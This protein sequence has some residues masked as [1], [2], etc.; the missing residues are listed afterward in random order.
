MSEPRRFRRAVDVT[1]RRLGRVLL[2]YLAL[3]VAI[4]TLAPFNFHPEAPHGLSTEWTGLDLVLN[5]VMF[6]PL[7]FVHALMQ[8]RGHGARGP[9]APRGAP[10]WQR[11][12]MPLLAFAVG[13]SGTIE[14]L[15]TI[16]PDRYP[17]LLDLG[18]NALGALGGGWLFHQLVGQ[19]D[20]GPV[21]RALSLELPLM[22]VAY[23]LVPLAWLAGLGATNDP[24]RLWLMLPLAAAAGLTLGT[25]HGRFVRHATR[26]HRLWLVIGMGLWLVVSLLPVAAT[27]FEPAALIAA[28]AVHPVV[29]LTRSLSLGHTAPMRIERP[30]VVMLVPLLLFVV[31]GSA[32]W[33]LWSPTHGIVPWHWGPAMVITNTDFTRPGLVHQL[34]QVVA[35]TVVGYLLAE[36]EGRTLGRRR[37]DLIRLLA[38]ASLIAM[39][40]EAAHGIVPG[41]GSSV[42]RLMASIASASFGG[43]VYLLFRAQ[44]QA[45]TRRRD[46][47]AAVA[48]AA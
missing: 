38:V 23:L 1:A 13:V 43:G 18:T 46:R 41:D 4:V 45:L 22:A 48:H 2:A 27:A 30:T 47:L 31:V 24:S 29:A 17:S 21:V 25:V 42:L 15:Q 9:A 34:M 3:I 20:E 32:L 7:G 37:R 5:V 33:P 6:L 16:I 44:V 12:W 10:R 35:F 39:G 28:L 40:V 26:L 14:L 19:D 36:Y 11:P 8:P